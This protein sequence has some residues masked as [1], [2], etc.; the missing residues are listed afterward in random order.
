MTEPVIYVR[1]F[2]GLANRMFRYMFA[3][4]LSRKTGGLEIVGFNMPEW[5]LVSPK[6]EIP[7]GRGLAT[8]RVHKLDADALAAQILR[9]NVDWIDVDA[10][11]MR[12]EDLSQERWRFAELFSC[13]LGQDIGDD[14]IAIHVRTGECVDGLHPDYTPIPL[15]FYHRVVFETSLE[16]VFVGQTTGNWYADALRR[17]FG[18]A[19]F[20]TNEPMA[21]FQTL[22]RAK[23]VV[24]AVSSFSWLAAFLSA[25]AEQIHLPVAGLL[26]PDQRPD[27]DL[28]PH[29]DE[30]YRFYYF[31][32]EKYV[33]NARQTDVL[34]SPP[35]W[36]RAQP[37]QTDGYM[38]LH[39]AAE[40][41]KILSP[42]D[43]AARSARRHGTSYLSVLCA[44]ETAKAIFSTLPPKPRPRP[45]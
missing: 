13:P 5:G 14:E 21:D 37:V 18:E 32:P 8:G 31:P 23:N 42:K 29:S 43:V 34:A 24:A 26:N 12:L 33:A 9:G 38:G 28:L 19:R 15:A 44:W 36:A 30:R 3:D 27:I 35:A 45:I 4:L 11:A 1:N 25:R 6:Q 10:F 16:P 40:R 39:A 7:D 2:G 17:Q 41:P 22:R 20:I